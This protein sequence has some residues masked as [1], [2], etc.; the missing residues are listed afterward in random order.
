MSNPQIEILLPQALSELQIQALYVWL[1][2][3]CSSVIRRRPF[4]RRNQ[5]HA[6]LVRER[7]ELLDLRLQLWQEESPNQ[8]LKSELKALEASIAQ[9]HHQLWEV[10]VNNGQQFGVNQITMSLR[11]YLIDVQAFEPMRWDDETTSALELESLF[12]VMGALPK[13]RVQII[14]LADRAEDHSLCAFMAA[15]LLSYYESA[16]AKLWLRPFFHTPRGQAEWT[17]D[18][19]RKLAASLHGQSYEIG[20]GRRE[21][22]KSYHLLNDEA[23]QDWA[24]HPRFFLHS[25]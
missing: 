13:T 16:Y 20:F 25:S 3:V 18:E 24:N 21:S 5:R 10:A 23:L 9:K 6:E 4:E 22:P 7:R 12:G 8:A 15:D 14:G 1:A 19:S 11:P 2:T 17:I